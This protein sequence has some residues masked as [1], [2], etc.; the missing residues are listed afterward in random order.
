MDG[1]SKRKVA[2]TDSEED[3]QIL[4]DLGLPQ[5]S[6]KITP[7]LHP[8]IRG[9]KRKTR[10]SGEG[11]PKKDSVGSE[12]VIFI[13]DESKDSD[14]EESKSAKAKENPPGKDKLGKSSI[15]FSIT[16]IKLLIL[17]IYLFTS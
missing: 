6:F 7:K 17:L 4:E 16:F 13:D 12:H 5:R 14:G 15:Y 1:S 11:E 8:S 10:K 9:Q 3:V 2:D